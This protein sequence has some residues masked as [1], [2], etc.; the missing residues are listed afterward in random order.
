MKKLILLLL[1]IWCVNLSYGQKH[2]QEGTL[3]ISDTL[4]I[5]Y[6]AVSDSMDGD[7]IIFLSPV[8]ISQAIFDSL[9]VNYIQRDTIDTLVMTNFEVGYINTDTLFI[10]HHILMR[11]Y[12]DTANAA[13]WPY[14]ML[15]DD[16]PNASI[17]QSETGHNL[18]LTNNIYRNPLTGAWTRFDSLWTYGSAGIQL[19]GGSQGY[20]VDRDS[21][22]NRILFFYNANA[23]SGADTL[24]MITMAKLDFFNRGFIIT[25]DKD[26]NVA[27]ELAQKA[28]DIRGS[29]I[30][31]DTLFGGKFLSV[32]KQGIGSIGDTIANSIF[33]LEISG[34]DGIADTLKT[35]DGTFAGIFI[36][37]DLDT[38]D[39]SYYAIGSKFE[40]D[41]NN[42][43]EIVI[44]SKGHAQG[45]RTEN[46]GLQGTAEADSTQAGYNYGL[47]VGDRYSWYKGYMAIRDGIYFYAHPP[48]YRD[49][50][51]AGTMYR[52]A[53][54]NDLHLV[55]M[56]LSLDTGNVQLDTLKLVDDEQIAN[57]YYE[58]SDSSLRYSDK[59]IVRVDSVGSWSEKD[60]YITELN[61]VFDSTLS[62]SHNVDIYYRIETSVTDRKIPVIKIETDKDSMQYF[63]VAV[64]NQLPMDFLSFRPTDG[65]GFLYSVTGSDTFDAKVR[66]RGWADGKGDALFD[67]TLGPTGMDIS[68][69]PTSSLND[70]ITIDKTTTLRIVCYFDVGVTSGSYVQI[71][72]LRY[73]YFTKSKRW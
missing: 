31:R 71:G 70:T 7:T 69:I 39:S 53:N 26:S 55:N 28:W 14:I 6:V 44:G 48:A 61:P 42:K 47:F 15:N 54:D 37:I 59:Y 49:S 10:E 72:N 3:L 73:R 67:T 51:N 21:T 34:S 13:L 46:Y 62:D 18:N 36:S 52:S 65:I 24:N 56:G 35:S 38:L 50:A 64:F 58:S 29:A 23:D 1:I 45:G 30:I 68:F 41:A 12:Y 4:L 43:S 2:I 60:I 40:V 16:Q 57:V 22:R 17:I 20:T 25:S 66:W 63:T 9:L 33:K 19:S 32:S 5:G 11:G 8:R 27:G